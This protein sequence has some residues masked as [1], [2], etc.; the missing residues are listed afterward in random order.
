MGK[1]DNIKAFF[2]FLVI[3][4]FV[5]GGFILMKKSTYN[6][7]ETNK[8]VENSERQKDIR[9]DK[10]KDYIYYSNV[11]EVTHELDIEYKE[12]NLNFNDENK[13]ASFLNEET[14]ELRNTIKYDSSIEDAPYNNLVSGKYKIYSTYTY[15]KYIS[16]VVD[17]YEYKYETLVTYLYTKTYVFN[18][19]TGEVISTEK[20]LSD[21]N[22]TKENVLEKIKK[23]VTDE[24][25]GKVEEEL[26]IE[27]T[28]SEIKEYALFVDKIGRLSIS[29][30]VK[31]NQKDYNEVIILN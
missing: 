16:L 11:E 12:V 29:I 26:D 21:F 22:L 19:N 6:D 8:K 18:K 1:Y 7:N 9:L 5:F 27:A 23:H 2:F 25:I 13:I 10:S 24:N 20:L 14:K 15:D 28:V 30:L 3:L 31:S 17:Y 4:V